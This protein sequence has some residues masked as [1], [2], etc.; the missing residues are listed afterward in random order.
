MSADGPLK[1]LLERDTPEGRAFSELYD[2]AVGVI[3]AM[4]RM[5]SRD[6]AFRSKMNE[7][8]V[9]RLEREETTD[10]SGSPIAGE[11]S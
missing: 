6:P 10:V 4:H 9:R 8:L 7:V 5:A 3:R 11:F 1:T 2:A